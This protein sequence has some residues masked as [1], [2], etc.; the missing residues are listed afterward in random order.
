MPPKRKA[1]SKKKAPKVAAEQSPIP[2]EQSPVLSPPEIVVDEPA[3]VEVAEPPPP[4][5][6]EAKRMIEEDSP[7]PEKQRAMS[8]S[9]AME[10]DSQPKASATGPTLTM[11]ERQA[12][13]DQLRAKMV[14]EVLKPR[15]LL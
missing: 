9:G 14:R 4:P 11:E 1:A 12:K 8:D 3:P 5:P 15:I 13:L 6:V 2:V 7:E 10:V